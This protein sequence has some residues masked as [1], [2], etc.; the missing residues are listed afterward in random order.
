M[1]PLPS[2]GRL[3]RFRVTWGLILGF[4]GIVYMVWLFQAWLAR[5][6]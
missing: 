1:L 5:L 3:F 6:S 2:R 4:F